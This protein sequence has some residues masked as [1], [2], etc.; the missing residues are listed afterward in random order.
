MN[1]DNQSTTVL[2][3][4]ASGYIAQHCVLQLLQQGYRVRGTLRSPAREEKLRATFA[5]H[6]DA[7]D[8][9]EFVAADLLSDEGWA[10]AAAGCRFV[11]HI[12]S[13]ARI[14]K[15]EDEVIIPARDGTK[16][17]L[18]AAAGAGAQRVVLTS[19]LAAISET[20]TAYSADISWT[21]RRISCRTCG[22]GS[23]IRC[24]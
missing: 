23:S 24:V 13:P 22:S 2:V 18:R 8:R 16:R 7:G 17:V 4:G 5:R 9:L 14:P 21:R 1:E 15:D 20:G 12:A 19:S 10:E 6:V 3:T 11:L